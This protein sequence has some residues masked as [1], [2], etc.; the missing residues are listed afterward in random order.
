MFKETRTIINSNKV[1][2][3]IKILQ[4]SDIHYYNYKD[5]KKLNKIYDKVKKYDLDYICIT[6]DLIDSSLSTDK[7]YFIDWIN[8]LKDICPVLISLGNHDI[9]SKD[10]EYYSFYDNEYYDKLND[11]DNVYLLNNNSKSLKDIYFYGYTQSFDY[12][13]L[14]KKED[15]KIML[16][17]LDGFKVLNTNS[18]KFNILLMHSPICLD[19][20]EI[21]NKLKCYDLI[22]CGHMHNGV[23]LPILDDIIKSNRGLIAPRNALFPKYARGVVNDKNITVI[24][25]GVTKLS[26]S[27]KILKYLN[28]IFP[29]GINIIEISNTEEYRNTSKYFI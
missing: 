9:R 17:E 26:N 29:I 28:F 11:L 14:N 18:N 21:N 3:D 27:A 24:S 22:L 23:I 10:D 16:K 6:G 25:S 7:E 12:Y 4:L 5:V 13:Y 19:N 20:K 15:F 2:K 1:K 8:K